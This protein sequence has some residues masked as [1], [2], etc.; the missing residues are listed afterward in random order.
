MTHKALDPGAACGGQTGV[1]EI[2]WYRLGSQ[3]DTPTP[4]LLQ[5][6]RLQNRFNIAP[7][8]SRAVAELAYPRIARRWA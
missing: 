5:A 4:L 6:L 7:A 8:T 2:F 3:E 1:G